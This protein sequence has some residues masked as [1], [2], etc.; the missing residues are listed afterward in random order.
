VL[1]SGIDG[2]HPDFQGRLAEARSFVGGSPLSDG[3]GHGTMVAGE[4]LAAAGERLDGHQTVAPVD[5][6]IGKIVGQGGNIDVG[7]EAHAIRWAADNGARV[8]NLSLGGRRDP[9]DPALNGYSPA[10]DAAVQYAYRNGA[11][12]VAATGN[13]EDVC[14]YGF[15]SYPAALAH[16]LAVS[17]FAKGGATPTFSNRDIRRNDLA[18]PGV[19][20]VSTYPPAL[21]MPGCADPGYSICATDQDYRTGDG[22][23][24]AAPLASAAAALLFALQPALTP[25]QVMTILERAADPVA[26]GHSPESGFG[27]LDVARALEALALPLPQPNSLAG[28]DSSVG[29]F[30]LGGPRDVVRARLDYSDDPVDVYAIRLRRGEFVTAAVGG[31]IANGAA[32]ALVAPTGRDVRLLSDRVFAASVVARAERAPLLALMH[33]ARVAG[34]YELVVRTVNPVSGGYVLTVRRSIRS[35]VGRP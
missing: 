18:A 34:W 1:D 12:V 23:S 8:I 20:I 35:P 6:L 28:L 7:V 14:P 32:L 26:R 13:C 31:Q 16:V 5:L 4:I 9:A 17:A 29:E 15:A 11:V 2:R 30:R 10:E 25:S 3:M 22:T 21:S 24:F 27:H 33:R 19:G